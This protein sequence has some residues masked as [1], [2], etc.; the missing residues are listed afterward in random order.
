MS[1]ID[2]LNSQKDKLKDVHYMILEESQKDLND[3]SLVVK[4]LQESGI[5]DSTALIKNSA[6]I[7]T[8]H[9]MKD[10]K[11]DEIQDDFDKLPKLYKSPETSGFSK[12][13]FTKDMFEILPSDHNLIFQLL[14]HIDVYTQIGALSRGFKLIL[15]QKNRLDA[16]RIPTTAVYNLLMKAYA[17]KS[18]LDKVFEIYDLMNKNSVKLDA[19]TFSFLLQMIGCMKGQT[20]Q[21]EMLARVVEDMNRSGVFFDDVLNLSQSKAAH[22]EA[23][24]RCIRLTSPKYQPT[25]SNFDQT[26]DC[27]LLQNLQVSSNRHCPSEGVVTLDELRQTVQTQIDAEMQQEVEVKN[28]TEFTGD[29]NV[30]QQAVSWSLFNIDFARSCIIVRY[31]HV[32][33]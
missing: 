27:K 21:A 14:A 24:L 13:P 20:K 4:E 11:E 2:L 26:Y 17:S 15:S 18:Q 8:L 28:I 16:S 29:A 7:E 25:Y 5:S 22:R 6:F 3:K 31:F 1:D 10:D 23:I 32:A 12:I 19:E 30:R 33:M 9:Q